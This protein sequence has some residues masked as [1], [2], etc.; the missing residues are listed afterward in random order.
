LESGMELNFNFQLNNLWRFSMGSSAFGEMVSNADL[1]GGPSIRYPGSKGFYYRIGT[2]DQKNFAVTFSQSLRYG[3]EDYMQSQNYSAFLVY[4]PFNAA[5]ISLSPSYFIN[6]NDLQYVTDLSVADGNHRYILATVDQRI[7]RLT[8]RSTVNI[9]PNLTVELWAQPF[10]AT[11][12]YDEF[13]KTLSPAATQFRE[14]F[15]TYQSIEVSRDNGRYI[16]T[17]NQSATPFS[18]Q[19]PDFNIKEFRS[20][21]VMRWEYI[22]GSTFF[23]V[24]SS[25]G[26]V[27]SSEQ[28]S[29]FYAGTRQLMDLAARNTFLMKY[30]YRF[31]L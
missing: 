17:E 13:K 12:V 18:F 26:S 30:T 28:D 21:L 23:L 22:P 1:R 9:T 31:I 16:I 2:N 6:R 27:F 7:Y 20:N 11:G 8:V 15:E 19:N 14:R 25:N 29:N 4:R 3:N 5:S 10:I 24:W